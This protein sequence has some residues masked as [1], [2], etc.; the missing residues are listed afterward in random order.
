MRVRSR[1]RSRGSRVRIRFRSRLSRV[2][3][4]EM[5]M[6]SGT[7]LEG[8]VYYFLRLFVELFKLTIL[9]FRKKFKH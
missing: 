7:D 9:Q 5:D 4:R 3:C 8:F 6:K 1:V 2:R